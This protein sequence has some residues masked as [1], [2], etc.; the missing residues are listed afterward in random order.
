[1]SET[2]C[3]LPQAGVAIRTRRVASIFYAGESKQYPED[4]SYYFVMQTVVK[5]AKK[6]VLHCFMLHVYCVQPVILC[7][8]LLT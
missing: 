3:C 1:M 5:E 4:K 2:L 8:K 7:I 6:N